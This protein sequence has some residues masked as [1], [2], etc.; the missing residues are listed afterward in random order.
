V[1]SR[2]AAGGNQ[3]RR[4]CR[5]LSVLPTALLTSYVVRNAEFRGMV[6]NE[7][8]E[9]AGGR[10]QQLPWAKKRGVGD[11]AAGGVAAGGSAAAAGTTAA[12]AAAKKPVTVQPGQCNMLNNTECVLFGSCCC[13]TR[14]CCWPLAVCIL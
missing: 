10:Q 1:R 9:G 8:P 7:L 11:A 13:C 4:R 5:C 3:N 12:T 14:R 6:G 2:G